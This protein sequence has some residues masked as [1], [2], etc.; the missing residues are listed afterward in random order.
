[1]TGDDLEILVKQCPKLYKLKIENNEINSI[2]NFKCLSE[3]K[4]LKKINV[5]GNPFCNTE[6]NFKDKLFQMLNTLESVDS[7]NK[8]G[9]DVESSIYVEDDEEEEEEDDENGYAKAK[10]DE[11][12]DEEYDEDEDDEGEEFNDDDEDEDDDEDDDDEDDEKPKKRTQK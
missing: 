12:E 3:L 1:M 4:E 11:E 8:E 5:K 10:D 6:T 2:D 7:H 9:G